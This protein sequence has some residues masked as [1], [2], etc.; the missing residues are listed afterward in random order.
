MTGHRHHPGYTKNYAEF[1]ETCSSG[2]AHIKGEITKPRTVD[3]YLERTAKVYN[4]ASADEVR[5]LLTGS[6]LI[7]YGIGNGRLCVPVTQ[8][9][10][11]YIGIDIAERQLNE[12]R[13][14]YKEY[15]C[16]NWELRQA[17]VDFAEFN[18]K[19]FVTEA[20]IQHFP[21]REY[22]KDFANNVNGSGV[23]CL[24]LQTRTNK[25]DRSE[26]DPNSPLWACKIGIPY[27]RELFFAYDLVYKSHRY[28]NGYQ[29]SR[30]T[31]KNGTKIKL[32]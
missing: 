7:D 6:T 13:A 23:E 28:G 29:Y 11:R 4:F 16:E 2:F 3:E 14:L 32:T 24:L 17:P 9:G 15:K 22:L 30:W 10:C 8:L 21:N 31:L 20:C 27:L 1:W 12:A 26:F 19:V 25:D 5:A 18:A